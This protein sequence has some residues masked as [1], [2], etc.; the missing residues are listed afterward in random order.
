[1]KRRKPLKKAKQQKLEPIVSWADTGNPSVVGKQ[2][3]VNYSSDVRKVTS[4]VRSPNNGG[5]PKS[6]MRHCEEFEHFYSLCGNSFRALRA[7]VG[8]GCLFWSS[9]TGHRMCGSCSFSAK[10]VSKLAALMPGRCDHARRH[11]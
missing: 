8:C 7:C 6:E 1:M 2:R 11:D 3:V 4:T 10:R 9:G 5:R